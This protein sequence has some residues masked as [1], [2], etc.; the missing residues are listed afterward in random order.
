VKLAVP[1]D[2]YDGPMMRRAALHFFDLAIFTHYVVVLLFC[3]LAGYAAIFLMLQR[4]RPAKAHVYAALLVAVALAA[5]WSRF[6]GFLHGDDRYPMRTVLFLATA[7]LGTIAAVHALAADGRLN[8]LRPFPRQWMAGGAAARALLG[9]VVI[10][11]LVHAGETVRF[12][13]VWVDYKAAVRALAMGAA[14]DAALGDARFVSSHRIGPGLNRLSWFSTTQ[15]FSV[16]VATGFTP[17]RLVVDP[18]ANYFWL[19]CRTA[20]ANETAERAMP[21]ESRRL[22]R[23]HACLH[24]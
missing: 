16:L 1:P 11:T 15:F 22:I 17:A 3:A 18:T 21:Q 14:S 4:F 12:L 19:S 5:Y 13:R 2:A 6:D 20:R 10:V 24:R 23:I 8:P 9:A 7:V